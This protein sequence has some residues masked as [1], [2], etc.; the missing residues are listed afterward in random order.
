MRCGPTLPRYRYDQLMRLGLEGAGDR[1]LR[2][3]IWSS[4]P[5]SKVLISVM[6]EAIAFYTLAACILGFGVLVISTK[7]TVHSVL[8]LVLNF[9]FVAALYILLGAQTSRHPDTRLRR[10]HRRPVSLRHHAREPEAAAG[11]TPG[12]APD[13]DLGI[14]LAASVLAE[15][16]TIRVVGISPAHRPDRGVSGD[17]RVRQHRAGGLAFYRAV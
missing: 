13:D 7:N 5:P 16:S 2:S 10:R 9:L 8:F 3:R 14:S 11:G 1:H 4:P 6:G 12:S 15:V 17:P